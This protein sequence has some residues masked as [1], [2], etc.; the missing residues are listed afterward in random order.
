M[1]TNLLNFYNVLFDKNEQICLSDKVYGIQ[2][3]SFRP[4]VTQYFSINPMHTSRA[5]SNV[6]CYR[7]ILIEFDTLSPDEQLAKLEAVP[8]STLTWSGGKSY[9]AIIS[10]ET[11][12][13]TAAEYKALVK[14]VQAKLPDMDKST[15]NPSRFSRCPG[16][17]RDNGNLQALQLVVGRISRETMS[18]WL[19]PAPA[20]EPKRVYAGKDSERRRILSGFTKHFWMF[21][22]DTNRN[23]S[24]FNAAC[25]TLRAGYTAEEVEEKAC[26]VLDLELKEIRACIKSAQK[27]VDREG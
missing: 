2:L 10:L 24:L 18:N 23:K 20:D 6:T 25:D 7:N 13:A 11:P 5:D 9:H 22:T 15:G 12:C 1:E 8:Y 3:F 16:V 19:G 4:S 17:K 26:E 27:T 14:L 21:G